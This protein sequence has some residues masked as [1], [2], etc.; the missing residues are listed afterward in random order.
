M[1][2]RL[3]AIDIDGTLMPSSGPR[4]SSRNCAAVRAAEDAGI[5]IVIATGRRHAYA[6]P[7]IAPLGLKQDSILLSSNGAV[8]RRLAGELLER[9]FLS[10]GIARR[11]CGE[12]R[13]YG[14]LLFTFDREGPAALVM[15]STATLHSRIQRW[16]EANRPYLMEV[17]PLERALEGAE[18]PIQSMVCGGVGEMR[19]AE[20]RLRARGLDREISMHRTEYPARDLSMLDLLP[21]GCSK[22]TALRRLAQMRGLA[23]EEVMAIGDNLNDLEML[24]YAGRAIVMANAGPELLAVAEARGWERAATNDQDGVALAI[25]AVLS[26]SIGPGSNGHHL[27]EASAAQPQKWPQED[28]KGNTALPDN[29]DTMARWV[30]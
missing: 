8:A 18:L 21:L 19:V 17:R 16:V 27:A 2:I 6:M 13:D 14:T 24:E 11:L 29:E 30:R 12:L 1:S 15:E 23:R 9:Q 4:I 3:I 10:A 28:P 26:E 7:L 25:D 5:E 22:G 20:E